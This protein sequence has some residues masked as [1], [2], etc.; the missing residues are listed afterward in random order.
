MSSVL[1][2]ESSAQVAELVAW[3]AA[4][5]APLEVVGRGSKQGL[6]RPGRRLVASGMMPDD[7]PTQKTVVA[8]AKRFSYA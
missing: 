3:A 5:Q 8:L 1:R 2:P 6:G 4:E 7:G